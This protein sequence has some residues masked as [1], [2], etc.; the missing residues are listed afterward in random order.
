MTQLQ[1]N[2]FYYLDYGIMGF[3]AVG[4]FPQLLFPYRKNAWLFNHP[5][6]SGLFA[7][8]IM[9]PGR[10]MIIEDLLLLHVAIEFGI[11][12]AYLIYTYEG[13]VLGKVL[14]MIIELFTATAV[15]FGSLTLFRLIY[16][17]LTNQEIWS[18]SQWFVMIYPIPLMLYFLFSFIE[19][20]IWRIISQRRHAL[21]MLSFLILPVYQSIFLVLYLQRL[22]T[23]TLVN[24]VKGLSV[25]IFSILLDYLLFTGIDSTWSLIDLNEK[26][27]ALHSSAELEDAYYHEMASHSA[28]MEQMA[29]EFSQQLHCIR[30]QIDS[31]EAEQL[32]DSILVKEKKGV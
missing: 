29:D 6:K 27:H 30:E 14:T 10:V 18:R 32:I 12:L 16:P 2:L 31:P 22:T 1:I 8:C 5:V 7:F 19:V 26:L 24:A 20:V 23:P 13:S 4:M 21:K 25:A 3:L 17:S 15:D 11:I 28:E 9:I